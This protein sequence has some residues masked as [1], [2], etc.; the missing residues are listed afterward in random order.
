M[1]QIEVFTDSL[2]DSRCYCI[3]EE[4]KVLIIDPNQGEE[5]ITRFPGES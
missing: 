3:E 2:T 4:G 5:V 1:E